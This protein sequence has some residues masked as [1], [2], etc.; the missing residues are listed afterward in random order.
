MPAV[1]IEDLRKVYHGRAVIDGVSL[2]VQPGEIFGILGPDGAGK[3]TA[4]EC[5]IGLRGA[6]RPAR[7][8]CS[9]LDP[10]DANRDQVRQVV[11]VQLQASAFP[12]QASG[13]A[14]SYDM[15]RSFYRHPP[16][17]KSAS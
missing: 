5:A 3:T 7:S 1:E 8:G 9:A 12:A 17:T 14:R 11:G 2:T 13:W 10:P 4:I 15:Y 16:P 6:E